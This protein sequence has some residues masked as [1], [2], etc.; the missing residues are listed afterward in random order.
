VTKA[1]VKVEATFKFNVPL[2]FTTFIDFIDDEGKKFQIPISGTTDNSIFTNYSF[3]QRHPDEVKIRHEPGKPIK[4]E[5]DAASDD[6]GSVRAKHDLPAFDR[7]KSKGSNS[8]RTL[9][10]RSLLGFSPID[11]QLLL[12]SCTYIRNWFTTTIA[13]GSM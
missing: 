11:E 3:I 2:S 6:E 9:T 1:K 4:I 7:Q 8:V 13:A 10:N 12:R 5:E